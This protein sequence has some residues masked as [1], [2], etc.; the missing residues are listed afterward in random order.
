M[1]AAI[2]LVCLKMT[3]PGDPAE[4]RTRAVLFQT[5]TACTEYVK[6][7]KQQAVP[8]RFVVDIKC[9]LFNTRV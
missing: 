5:E 1:Y 3:V 4:C 2:V 9:T 8:E 7:L 6:L